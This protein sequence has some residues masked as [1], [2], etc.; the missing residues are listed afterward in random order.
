MKSVID[1]IAVTGPVTKQFVDGPNGQ[2]ETSAAIHEIISARPGEF[3][4]HGTAL[5]FG[6]LLILVAGLWFIRFPDKLEGPASITTE[7]LPIRIK[8]M[9]SG[10]IVRMFV[11][12]GTYLTAGQPIAELNHVTGYEKISGLEVLIGQVEDALLDNDLV[13]LRSFA[14]AQPGVM[15]EAQP[16]FNALSDAIGDYV[17]LKSRSV[18]AVRAASLEAQSSSYQD[19]NVLSREE[20]RLIADELAQAG[21][22]FAAN[23]RLYTERIISRQEY[24]EEASRLRARELELQQQRR[25]GILNGLAMTGSRQQLRDLQYEEQERDARQLGAIR[26]QVRNLQSF[27]REWRLRNLIVAPVSGRLHFLQPLQAGDRISE[28]AELCAIIPGDHKY[29]AKLR[30]PATGI[31]KIRK[32]LEVQLMPD[33]YPPG[34]FGYLIGR[35]REVSAMPQAG[36]DGGYLVSVSLPDS[37]VTTYGKRLPFSPELSARAA[38]IT[39]DRNL[40]QRLFGGFAGMRH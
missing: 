17:L 11:P 3:V 15:G 1:G 19:L 2:V 30:L 21:E 20:G 39:E 32:A 24:F 37:L 5:I 31:G 22:R 4:R 27:I 10:Q 23:E 40:L 14:A 18:Y 36:T 38:V 8:G 29:T 26:A 34:E 16:F 25:T 12:E 35:V 33:H 7:P 6:L 9:S 13:A 28:G